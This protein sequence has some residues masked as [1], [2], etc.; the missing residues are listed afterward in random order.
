MA[1]DGLVDALLAEAR[2]SGVDLSRLGI[3]WARALPAAVFVPAFGLGFLSLP[4]RSV[5]AFGLGVAIAPAVL[6]DEGGGPWLVAVLAAFLRGLPV[7][8]AA[9]VSLWAAMVAGGVADT[10]AGSARFRPAP[11]ALGPGV[12]PFATL[13]ALLA[14]IA[15]LETGGA[16]RVALRLSAASGPALQDAVQDLAA[17]VSLGAG[18]GAPLLV[19]SAVLDVAMSVVTQ[20]RPSVLPHGAFL[21]LRSLVVL[22]A[23]AAVFERMA[24]AT[25]L[26]AGR[27]P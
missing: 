23:S 22:V 2:F 25:V 7:A 13:L 12:T 14:S 26:F 19:V 6:P 10:A 18:I 1:P 4:L 11:G 20:D 17:G 9:S 27:A 5:I 3:A 16:S 8:V 15:F 21:P 24:E